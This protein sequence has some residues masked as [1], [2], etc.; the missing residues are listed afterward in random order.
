MLHLAHLALGISALAL[1]TAVDDVIN[2]DFTGI[3]ADACVNRAGTTYYILS[4]ATS[5]PVSKLP[6]TLATVIDEPLNRPSGGWMSRPMRWNKL[7]LKTN[8]NPRIHERMDPASS[9]VTYKFRYL[10]IVR[11]KSSNSN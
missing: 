11:S 1:V 9:Q 7:G 8:V 5:H 3:D 10:A 2:R 6:L 4:A